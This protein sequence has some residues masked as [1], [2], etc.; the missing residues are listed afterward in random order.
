MCIDYTSLNKACPKDRFPLTRIDQ[1]MD[2][3]SGCDLLFFIDAYFG[4]HQI[5]MSWE[6]EEHITFIIV[7]GL[8]CYVSMPYVLKNALPTFMRVV[9][10]TIGDSLETW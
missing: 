9:H 2:S 4:F 7:D 5:P 3:T 6:D 10:K 1:I 8:F